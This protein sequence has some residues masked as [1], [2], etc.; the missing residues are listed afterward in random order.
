MKKITLREATE[1]QI[2]SHIKMNTKEWFG[3]ILLVTDFFVF[4][5]EEEDALIV[6]CPPSYLLE[7]CPEKTQFGI[8]T[9]INRY[10]FENIDWDTEIEVPEEEEMKF[11]Y[12]VINVCAGCYSGYSFSVKCPK[13][14]LEGDAEGKLNDDVVIAANKAGYFRYENDHCGCGVRGPFEADDYEIEG[15]IEDAR[16][17]KLD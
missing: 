17:I 14:G 4:K 12:W 8:P 11:Y 3:K 16:E 5:K 15:W 7:G 6:D 9:K 13:K 1:E 10:I 2:S